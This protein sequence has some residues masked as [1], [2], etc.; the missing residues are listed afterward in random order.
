VAGR[1]QVGQ[2]N[3]HAAERPPVLTRE[4]AQRFDDPVPVIT[5]QL[6]IGDIRLHHL[7]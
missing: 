1:P 2:C 3:F 6:V 7:R 4:L 5:E